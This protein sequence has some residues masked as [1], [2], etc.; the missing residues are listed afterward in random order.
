MAFM[1]TSNTQVITYNVDDAICDLS[2]VL[3][4]SCTIEYRIE[5][6]GLDN[7]TA[8]Y[9]NTGRI[10]VKTECFSIS[11]SYFDATTFASVTHLGG[12]DSASRDANIEAGYEIRDDA[13][14]FNLPCFQPSLKSNNNITTMCGPL[15]YTVL[16][17]SNKPGSYN[18]AISVQIHDGYE[19]KSTVATI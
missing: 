14:S 13:L 8:A 5:V 6:F 9:Q 3:V 4:D 11:L 10:I 18:D 17:N 19:L 7:K 12:I 2:D 1:V 16:V 15:V